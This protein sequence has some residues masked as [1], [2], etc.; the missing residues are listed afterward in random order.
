MKKEELKKECQSLRKILGTYEDWLESAV[1][2]H[3]LV[4][5]DDSYSTERKLNLF[6]ILS[7]Y[8]RALLS[9][10]KLIIY[11]KETK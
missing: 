1:N 9:L 5:F 11:N 4:E 2:H 8:Q 3:T 10:R 7:T 6:I